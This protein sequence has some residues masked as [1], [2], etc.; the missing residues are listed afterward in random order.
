MSL[1]LFD[2]RS[3]SDVDK[4]MERGSLDKQTA[5]C[6]IVDTR[7]D[8]NYLWIFRETRSVFHPITAVVVTY[9]EKI[10]LATYKAGLTKQVSGDFRIQNYVFA[11]LFR[12]AN[13]HRLA[14]HSE[15]AEGPRQ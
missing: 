8:S 12:S 3:V 1:Y 11:E 5:S 14:R 10:T 2:G 15:F 7:L 6:V 4:G 9:V 13:R